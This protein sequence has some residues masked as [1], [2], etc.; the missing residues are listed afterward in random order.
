MIRNLSRGVVLAFLVLASTPALAQEYAAYVMDAR[1]GKA[2]HAVNSD[3]KLA[4]ASLTKMM[5]LYI[6]F[7]EVKRGRLS[8]DQKVTIS[9]NAAAEPPSRLGLRA[10]QKIELRYL[11]RAAAIKSANDAATALG[12]AVAGSEPAFAERM[13]Q[14]ARAMGLQNTHF[15]NAHGLTA[16]GHYSS[17]HDMAE[18]GRRLFYDFPQYYNIFGRISTSAGIA[19]VQNTNRRLLDAYP[20]ADGI[21]TGYTKAAGFNLVSSAE[22]DNER[23]I[24][25]VFGGK[26]TA[27]R[28]AE[29]MRLMDLGFAKMPSRAKVAR[30]A[31]LRPGTA[32][33]VLVAAAEA[34]APRASTAGVAPEPAGASPVQ[35]ASAAA[36]QGAGALAASG[37]PMPRWMGLGASQDAAIARTNQS[38]ATAIAEVNAELAAGP[39]V[40]ASADG[41]LRPAPR[42]APGQAIAS[43]AG[44]SPSTFAVALPRSAQAGAGDQEPIEVAAGSTGG[45]AWGVQLGAFRSKG[46]AERHLLTMALKDLPQLNGG[47]RRIEAGKVQ[48]VT[49]YRAQFVGLSQQAAEQACVSLSRESATCQTLAPG[50]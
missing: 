18:I 36:P 15:A 30:P 11:I 35:V 10:G 44:G 29:V 5:T 47:L 27:S 41:A 4:P 13:N 2:V 49:L 25:A 42:P 14:Y 19:T 38:I 22:R 39:G 9:E 3:K 7:D 8:L 32:A 21:K 16:A 6:V 12:E 34:R 26:S 50:I 45:N 48:G 37:R 17:A 23:V 28:N 46:D 33:P 43:R 40:V 31:P 1:N 24:V 20:G